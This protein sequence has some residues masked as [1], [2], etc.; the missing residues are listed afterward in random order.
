MM[1]SMASVHVQTGA[2]LCAE[3]AVSGKFLLSINT[4]SGERRKECRVV[5]RIEDEF[6]VE[7]LD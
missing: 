1:T 7:F 3:G 2:R 5:W 6:G 4:D